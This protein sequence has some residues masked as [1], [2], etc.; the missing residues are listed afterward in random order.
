MLSNDLGG[1]YKASADGVDRPHQGE[2]HDVARGFASVASGPHINGPIEASALP[3]RG[4][5]S[6]EMH[7]SFVSS[8]TPSLT[9]SVGRNGCPFHVSSTCLKEGDV[10]RVQLAPQR[11]FIGI[12]VGDAVSVASPLR[13]RFRLDTCCFPS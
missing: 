9:H 7:G 5:I 12:D 10:L 13:F 3:P 8:N 6:R 1:G 11:A 4:I 2:L